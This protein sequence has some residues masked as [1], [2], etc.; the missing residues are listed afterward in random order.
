M[1]KLSIEVAVEIASRVG[2]AVADPLEDLG[3]LWATCSQMRRVCSDALVG[4]SIPLQRVLLRGTQRG[5]WKRF[6]DHEYH[7]KL[8]TRL[9]S[10]SNLE[11]YLY[12]GMRV[13]FVEDHD[14]LTQWLDA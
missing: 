7:A 2:A 5:T 14:T 6:Y 13:V 12:T 3:S 10:V 8:I 1:E 9:A 11:A 4:R